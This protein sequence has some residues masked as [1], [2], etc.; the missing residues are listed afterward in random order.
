MN[1]DLS[2]LW[3][4]RLSISK[5]DNFI[6]AFLLPERSCFHLPDDD[7]HAERISLGLDSAQRESGINLIQHL[8]SYS[9][10]YPVIVFSNSRTVEDSRL[11]RKLGIRGEDHLLKQD[12]DPSAIKSALLRH[13]RGQQV[14]TAELVEQPNLVD[15]DVDF[16]RQDINIQGYFKV[17]GV[18]IPLTESE[19][20]IFYAICVDDIE[21]QSGINNLPDRKYRIQKKITNEL[22]KAGRYVGEDEIIKPTPGAK[23]FYSLAASFIA[24]DRINLTKD[25]LELADEDS[26]GS[27]DTNSSCK[28]LIVEND[29]ITSDYLSK[30]LR[31][32]GFEVYVGSNVQEAVKTARMSK[33]EMLLLDLQ[34]PLNSADAADRTHWC[35]DAG[36]DALEE[37]RL[38]QHD[39]RA[40]GFTALTVNDNPKLINRAEN[41]GLWIDDIVS[42]HKPPAD[43]GTPE[44]LLF[45]KI[46]NL[47]TEITRGNDFIVRGLNKPNV[48]ILPGSQFIAGRLRLRINGRNYETVR[49]SPLERILGFLVLNANR[50]VT[51]REIADAIGSEVPRD[52]GKK[53]A[54]RL[55][56]RI[57]N[58]WLGLRTTESIEPEKR[59]LVNYPASMGGMQLNVRV[60][61]QEHADMNDD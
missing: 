45:T 41:L 11:L 26:A 19:K 9:S 60:T 24:G 20:R 27:T 49:V 28:V 13:I 54:E 47:R 50:L 38:F 12:G 51:L 55:R 48:E 34:L 33:P 61:G 6:E 25:E 31:R 52:R 37:I 43:G 23:G 17:D 4:A 8:R 3:A 2:C 30:E 56:S 22:N 44:S 1:H 36:L 57:R 42:K 15:G 5:G 14:H 18:A 21:Y 58:E 32:L 53:W 16:A 29:K 35:D 10:Q 46:E 59:I 40:V 7:K 39:I